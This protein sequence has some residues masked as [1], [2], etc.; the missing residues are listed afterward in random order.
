MKTAPD[1]AAKCSWSEPNKQVL[2]SMKNQKQ[3]QKKWATAQE[4][5]QKSD[6]LASGLKMDVAGRI[7]ETLWISLLSL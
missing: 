1:S 6:S 5:L 3:K 2:I 4:W 7:I